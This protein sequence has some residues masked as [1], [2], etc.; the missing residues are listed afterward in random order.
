MKKIKE[1]N[2]LG[3]VQDNT[4]LLFLLLLTSLVI[5]PDNAFASGGIEEFTRPLQRFVD[6][7]SGPWVKAIASIAFIITGVTL[8]LFKKAIDEQ[9]QTVL[10][11]VMGLCVVVAAGPMVSN[12]FG[13]SGALIA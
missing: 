8:A 7:L 13:F 2:F 9:I 3:N 4:V 5:F 11:I 12:F 1:L 10:F 6:L